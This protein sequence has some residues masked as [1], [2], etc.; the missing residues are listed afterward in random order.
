MQ[1]SQA[2][3]RGSET[4]SLPT[5]CYYPAS[6][7]PRMQKKLAFSISGSDVS[8]LGKG[9]RVLDSVCVFGSCRVELGVAMTVSLAFMVILSRLSRISRMSE[10]LGRDAT[11]NLMFLL[12][13][14]DPYPHPPSDPLFHILSSVN[15]LGTDRA[16]NKTSVNFPRSRTS[17]R[18]QLRATLTEAQTRPW[19]SAGP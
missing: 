9:G 2:W 7:W 18:A 17:V 6:R 4:W 12:T 3:R 16:V 11:M 15:K 1:R 13:V 10:P 5:P 19:F 14:P 8:G